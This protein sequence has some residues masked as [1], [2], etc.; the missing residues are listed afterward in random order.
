MPSE[1]KNV[2]PFKLTPTPSTKPPSTK[3]RRSA[4]L[5]FAHPSTQ[6]L[7]TPPHTAKQRPKT[8]RPSALVPSSPS[9]AIIL[10]S[11]EP[12]FI[13]V[14]LDDTRSVEILHELLYNPDAYILDK[15]DKD[16][17]A[18]IN[19]R[20][21]PGSI[22]LTFAKLQG[23]I[24]K[25]LNGRR[26]RVPGVRTFLNCCIVNGLPLFAER[27]AV[28]TLLSCYDR[29]YSI[30]QTGSPEELFVDRYLKTPSPFLKESN[31]NSARVNTPVSHDTKTHIAELSQSLGMWEES[32]A[33]AAVYE[34][35]LTQPSD[36]IPRIQLDRW[37]NDIEQFYRLLT[38]KAAG[39][40]G[41][42]HEFLQE[43]DHG[44]P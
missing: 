20:S 10:P 37:E 33:L 31:V 36:T 38:L 5:P 14:S 44:N 27:P 8:P 4:T 39:A 11:N 29:F 24:R 25:T 16:E 30:P 1:I 35:L 26:G 17:V 2:R 28:V 43:D 40:A 18:W 12:S 6:A 23:R 13:P 15:R 41:L 7:P 19:L 22:S 9:P 42:I 3:T 32:V 34:F 21:I